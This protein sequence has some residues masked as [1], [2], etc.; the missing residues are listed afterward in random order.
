[1]KRIILLALFTVGIFLNAIATH[2]RAGEI[3]YRYISGLTYEATITTYTDVRSP[4]ADRNEL[5]L[6]WGDGASSKLPRVNGGGAGVV[7]GNDIRKNEYV[8]RHTYQGPGRFRLTMEDPNRVAGIENIAGSVNV[9]FFIESILFIGNYTPTNNSP[10]LLNPPIDM[11]CVNKRFIHNPGATDPEGDSLSYSLVPVRG[12]NGDVSPNY[13]IPPNVTI[14]QLTGDMIWNT[15]QQQ[16][17]YNFAILITE[18]RRV[19]GVL[20]NVG[21]VVRDLQVSV[22]FCNNDPPVIAELRDTCIEAGVLLEL[23]V[24]ATDPNNDIITLSASGAPLLINNNPALFPEVTARGTVTGTLTW[25]PSCAQVRRNPYIVYFKAIDNAANIPLPD[26]KSLNITVVGPAPKNPAAEAR[27]NDI[28]LS[29]NISV[30]TEVT[31]YQIYRSTGSYGFVPGPCETG[32]PAYTGF[33][34]VGSVTGRS[35]TTYLDR[36]L[37]H[38]QKYCYMIVATFPDGALSYASEEVC[39]ELK[40]DVP[41]ITNADILTT[42]AQGSVRVAWSAPTE[43]NTVQFPGPYYYRVFRATGL[44]GAD[45]RLIDSTAVNTNIA[46]AD[47]IYLDT[48]A[49]TTASLSYRIELVSGSQRVGHTQIASAVFLQVS[50]VPAG[51]ALNV[52]WEL[53]VPWTNRRYDIFRKGPN[54]TTFDSLASTTSLAYLDTGL[55]NRQEYCYYIRSVGE[56]SIDGIVNPIVNNS[57]IVC[58]SPE[59]TEPPCPPILAINGDCDLEVNTLTWKLPQEI[60]FCRNDAVKYNIYF[61]PVLGG[62]FSKAAEIAGN[63]EN[64]FIHQRPN[65]IAGCY[66]ITAVDLFG[67]ETQMIDTVCVDNCPLYELPNVF[68][69][70]GDNVNDFFRPFPYK[71][72][73]SVDLKVFNRWGQIVFETSNPDIF[74]NGVNKDTGRMSTQGVYFYVCTVNEIRLQGI[75]PRLL[76]GQVHLFRNANDIPQIPD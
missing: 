76:Q 1:M 59:D 42:A 70:D 75:L 22:G 24:T 53:N 48:R 19:G 62:E 54:E 55:I 27:G 50:P 18:W 31:G 29:W 56:Y 13:F 3:T 5:E 40:K 10:V 64:Q 6:K 17:V 69:P 73:E 68:S 37:I 30:C 41:I 57:Q 36:D 74:W 9:P 14:N 46:L 47:T 72:V 32:V 39:E 8:G 20:V 35:D 71:F 21:S 25:T 33:S 58:A 4:Q 38:G 2:N 63:M 15:P 43:L 49:N 11:A 7:I 65:S 60:N 51:E 26:Y 67:N 61:T 44:T 45:L 34:L 52:S 28:A 66:Y 23:P 16:G 12:Q